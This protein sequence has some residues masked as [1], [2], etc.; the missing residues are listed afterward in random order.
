M[1]EILNGPLRQKTLAEPCSL[2]VLCR[3]CHDHK[4]LGQ[5]TCASERAAYQLAF[6]FRSRPE[7]YDLVRFNWLR[8]ENAPNFVTQKQVDR[9]LEALG[10]GFDFDFG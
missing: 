9:H 5:F 8:N 7:D 3:D 10:Y 2:L 6:V 1:H 4:V